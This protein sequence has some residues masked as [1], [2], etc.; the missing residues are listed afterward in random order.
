MPYKKSKV[1][2]PWYDSTYYEKYSLLW[3]VNTS[4]LILTGMFLF[5]MLGVEELSELYRFLF[6]MCFTAMSLIYAQ[7]MMAR[8]GLS[9]RLEV[10]KEGVSASA[11]VNRAAIEIDDHDML[12]HD[13]L[14]GK[15]GEEKSSLVAQT[16]AAE[17][18][19]GNPII[20]EP[21]R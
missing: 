20:E 13:Y 12:N 8:K 6:F 15:Q 9:M 5:I 18:P 16:T 2:T 19:V 17:D 14:M 4:Y 1:D 7:F 21:R 3:I 11:E 10:T